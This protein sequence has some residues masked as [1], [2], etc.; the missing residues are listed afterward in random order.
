MDRFRQIDSKLT[1]FAAKYNA[2]IHSS[3]SRIGD[4]PAEKIQERRIVWIDGSIGKAVFITP[5]FESKDYDSPLW[6]FTNL[7]WL[8]DSKPHPNG[9][10]FWAK[11]ILQRVEFVEIEKAIDD[12]LIR[13]AENLDSVVRKK[14]RR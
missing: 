6:N 1:N 5:L 3:G 7:A 12:L 9:V 14:L 10:P 4:V 2:E 8:V 13:S 11:H